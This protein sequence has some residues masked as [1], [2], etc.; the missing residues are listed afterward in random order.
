MKS[1]SAVTLFSI[2]IFLDSSVARPDCRALGGISIACRPLG[3]RIFSPLGRFSPGGSSDTLITLELVPIVGPATPWS[4]TSIGEFRVIGVFGAF[5][6]N[7][8]FG[9]CFP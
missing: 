8:Y 4:D 5:R 7:N 3:A 9:K 1:S 6:K 2:T